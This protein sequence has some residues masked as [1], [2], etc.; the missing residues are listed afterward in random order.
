MMERTVSPPPAQ[1]QATYAQCP[2]TAI[3]VTDTEKNKQQWEL[4]WQYRKWLLIKG[5]C[6]LGIAA[7]IAGTALLSRYI[8]K[9]LPTS[10]EKETVGESVAVGIVAPSVGYLLCKGAFF[11]KKKQTEAN[12]KLE[13]LSREMKALK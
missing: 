11:A 13:T 9:E 3:D 7:D 8:Y 5:I 2:E 12:D 1:D 6:Y 4:V 10:S